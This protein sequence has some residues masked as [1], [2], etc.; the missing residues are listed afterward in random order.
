MVICIFGSSKEGF[1]KSVGIAAIFFFEAIIATS[2][3]VF[4]F[5][6]SE[7]RIYGS[8]SE[9]TAGIESNSIAIGASVA[10]R[11]FVINNSYVY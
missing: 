4:A 3:F 2:A 10:Y 5:V 1:S 8:A 6:E 7:W 9:A 11:D